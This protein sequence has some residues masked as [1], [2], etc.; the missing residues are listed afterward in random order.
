MNKPVPLTSRERVARR[1]AALRAQR[2]RPKQI[3]LPDL[4]DP[5]V[6]REIDQ[7]CR[8]IAGSRDELEAVAFLESH[9]DWGSLPPFD[10]NPE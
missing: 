4:R 2:L 1:R 6:R 8:R 9:Y 5:Q 7:A 3:W 10:S